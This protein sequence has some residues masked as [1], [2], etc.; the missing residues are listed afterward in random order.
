MFFR[1]SASPVLTP[2]SLEKVLAGIVPVTI[3]DVVVD[4][5]ATRVVPSIEA[6][7][8]NFVNTLGAALKND[9]VFPAY[10][11]RLIGEY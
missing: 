7:I 2:H 1:F 6:G 11:A 10:Y 8:A 4:A 5:I 9:Q 3:K